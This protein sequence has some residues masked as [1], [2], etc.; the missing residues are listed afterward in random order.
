MTRERG[1]E[2]FVFAATRRGPAAGPPGRR[3]AHLV[4]GRRRRSTPSA[5]TGSC[6]RAAAWTTRSSRSFPTPAG[7]ARIGVPQDWVAPPD[8]L[9]ELAFLYYL[10]TA[11]LKVGATYSISR[12]FKTGY[13]PVQ[14][15]VTG[16]ETRAAA[17][18][19]SAPGADPRDHQPRQQR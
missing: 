8:P 3:R 12:Y 1:D 13:N 2:A 15:R 7:T 9:D 6:S 19:Q 14:V 17:R 5:F 11:P 4:R 18:R 16:R 10:R